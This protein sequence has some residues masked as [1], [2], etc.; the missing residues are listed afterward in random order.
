MNQHDKDEILIEMI[1][2]VFVQIEKE[3]IFYRVI[4]QLLNLKFTV[5]FVSIFPLYCLV[6]SKDN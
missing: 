5:C 1:K 4:Y 3:P 6:E 2:V